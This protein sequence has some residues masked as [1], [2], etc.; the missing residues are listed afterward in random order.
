MANGEQN[1][2]FDQLFPAGLPETPTGGFSPLFEP[3]QK[4]Q[5]VA[6]ASVRAKTS[7][8]EK[9]GYSPDSPFGEAI[10]MGA[11]LVSGASRLAGNLA[12]LPVDAISGMAQATVPDEM[13]QAYN[14]SQ[15]N[16]ASPE[17]L[18]L[19]NQ[20]VPGDDGI[21]QTYLQRIEGTKGLQDVG[22][23]VDDF[24]DITSIV[25]TT[26]RDRLSRDIK[27]ETKEGVEGIR[28][29]VEQ[30][31]EGNYRDALKEGSAALASTVGNALAA[32]MAQPGAVGEY[33]VEN[34]P[35]LA[36]A[37]VNPALALSTNAGYGFDV[38]REGMTDYVENNNGQL[39]DADERNQMAG[40]A[41]A[42][43]LA[44]Q[45]GDVTM[46]R[47]LRAAEKG[48]AG[49]IK[50]AASAAG[51]VAGGSA[52]EGV[53]EGFQTYAEAKAALKS[54]TLEEVV[55]GA[56]IGALVGGNF[57]G[58]AEVANAGV[59]AEQTKL[60]AQATEAASQEA[61]N[62]AV[63][64][65][66][67]SALADPALETYDPARAVDALNQVSQGATAEQVQANL[68]QADSIQQ[69]LNKRVSAVQASAE[70]A[71]ALR[72]AMVEANA[73]QA[74]MD[75]ID[76]EIATLAKEE[77]AL[78]TQLNA[79][80]ASAERMRIDTSPEQAD[81][82]VIA[83]EA[84]AGNTESADRI[85]TLTMTN[86][87][88]IPVEVAES[89]AQSEAL[90]VPQRTA[91][92]R[93][94][95]AQV[96]ANEL[97]GRTGVRS[98]I[99]TGGDGF[100]GIPQ[101]RNA[102]RMA[103]ANGNVEAARSQVDGLAS[104]A[105]SRVS[106]LEAITAAY[107][108]V[109]GTDAKINIV[110]DEQG[111]WGPTDLKGTALKKAGGL[112]IDRKSFKLRDDVSAEA[113]VLAKT[114]AAYSALVDA[115][116]APVAAPA[117]SPEAAPEQVTT[118]T[119]EP[120]EAT[121]V[122]E[123][124]AAPASVAETNAVEEAQP[125]ET[126]ED[127][128][129]SVIQNRTGEPVTAANY[130]QVN[131][132]GELF[133]QDAGSE[134]SASVRPLVAHKDFMSKVMAGE[135]SYSDVLAQEG[136]LTMPQQ[137]A[138]D[139]FT[140]F[141]RFAEQAVRDVFKVTETRAK[142]PDFFY[143]DMAQF[144]QGADGTLDENLVTAVSYGMFS[145]INENAT[146]LRNS[147]EGINAILL[148]DFDAEISPVERAALANLG[149]RE[150]VV[151]SQL[152]GRIM[153]ALGLRPTKDA[154]NAEMSKLEATIGARA[155]G[156]MSN[157]GLIT[158]EQLSDV[159]LQAL[160]KSGEPG[161]KNMPHTFVRVKANEVDGKMVA[162]PKVAR[163]RERNTGSQ[164]VVSKVFGVE[165]AGVE[166]SYQPVPF[167]QQFAKRTRQDVPKVLAETL[168]KEG[169]KAHKLR[170]NMWHVWGRLSKQAL[171]AM[172][173]AVETSDVP[174]HIE[175][176][177]GL[178][179]K[180]DGI[181]AQVDNLDSFIKTMVADVTTEGL[182]QSLYFGRSVWKPQRVGLST[183][184]INPQTSKVHRHMLA[185]EGW[186]AT[187]N[188]DNPAQL[189]N[190]QLRILEAFGVKTEADLTS[191]VLAGYAAK[192]TD[193]AAIQAGVDALVD[194]L[195][196]NSVPTDE[197]AI[198]AAVKEG[199]ENFHSFDAL[200][201]LAEEKIA[202]Q[203]N[204]TGFTTQMMGEVDGLTNGPMLSIA[205][206]GAKGWETLIQG[207]FMPLDSTYTQFNEYK[208]AGGLDLYESNIAAAVSRLQGANRAALDAL[209]VITGQLAT[210][211][212]K[213]TKKGRN[214]IK[215]PLTALMFG[216]N[217]TTAVEGMA[218]GFIDSIYSKM[219][220][221]AA[222]KSQAE[223]TE[224]L[225]ALNVL[226]LN[227]K[228]KLS[229]T[230]SYDEALNTRLSE[231]QKEE[232]KKSFYE[233]LGAPTEAALGDTYA[234]FIAR[235]NVINQTAQLA[236]NVYNAVRDG[237]TEHVTAGSVN[238]PRNVGGEAIRTL[239]RAQ[240][241]QVDAILK[242]MAPILQTA[243]S[244]ASEQHT[245]GMYMAKSQRRMDSTAPFES[246]VAFG[247]PVETIAM[248]GNMK[249]I[250]SSKISSA[251]VGDID[252]G[253]MP[254]ITSIHSMDS[255]IAS[256]VYGSMEA[257]NVHDALGVDLDNM[258]KVGQELNKATFN[259]LMNYSSATAMSNMLD[260]VLAGAARVLQDEALA[261]K[262]QPRL[263]A[264]AAARKAKKQG[265]IV[266]QVT[267]I[268]TTASQADT[269]KLTML[270]QMKAVGQ[271]ATEG[272]S[273]MVTEADRQA[274]QDA[275]AKVGSTF[276][277]ASRAIAE[278][279]DF[280]G[281]MDARASTYGAAIALS[282]A[283]LRTLAPATS[284]NT[285]ASLVSTPAVQET[286][287]VM[288]AQ[289]IPLASALEALPEEQAAEV[290]AAVEAVVG[291]K[292]S[293]WGQLGNPV[294]QSDVNLV[295]MLESTPDMT[296]GQLAAALE[297]YVADPFQKTLLKMVQRALPGNVQVKYITAATGPEGAYGEGVDKS[298]G[299][300]AQRSGKA[301]V[302]VKSPEFVE[303]G[304]TPEMLTHELVHAALANLV[305]QHTGKQSAVGRAVADLEAVRVS[306]AQ[307][308]AN[309]GALSAKYRNA[310][311]N[312]QELLA[313]GLTNQDF[314]REV[315]AMTNAPTRDTGLLHNLQKFIRK[316]TS[317]LFNG[318]VR[319]ESAMAALVAQSAGL[320]REAAALRTAQ[321]DTT[322]KYEDEMDAVNQ[323]TATQ[324][325]D[326]MASL[327][328]NKPSAQ[329][330]AYLRDLLESTV[331]PIYGPY[332]VTKEN[333]KRNM[334][335]TPLD[336]LLKAVQT[337]NMPFSSVAATNAFITT[338][339][340]AF[341]LESVE[342]VIQ[343]AMGNPNTLFV[344]GELESLY[345]K[346]RESLK[347]R[348]FHAGDWKAASANEKA[349]A[350]AKYDFL[351]RPAHTGGKS[352]YLSRFAA[353]GLA[354]QEVRNVLTF[355][356]GRADVPLASL[357]WASR[358]TELF[359]RIMTRLAALHTKVA[360]GTRADD[361]LTT[362]VEQL[363]DIE[364]KRK[365]Q[366]AEAKVI[367][368]DQIEAFMT[369]TAGTVR[370][371]LDALGQSA[372]MRESR[373]PGF[374]LAGVAMSTLA[375]DRLDA[376]LDHMT[377]ARDDAQRSRHGVVMGLVTEWRG[378]YDS[379]RLAS[380]LFKGAK[381][382]EQ[383]RK[384]TI[385][386]TVAHVNAAFADGG[387]NLTD[388][389]RAAITKFFLKTNAQA[390]EQAVGLDQLK[391]MLNDGALMAQYR[392]ELEAQVQALSPEYLYMISQTKDLAHHRVVGGSTSANLMQS[393]ANITAMFGTR[394]AGAVQP[395]LVPL[396][397]QL[398]AVYALD[399]SD[400][401]VRNHAM[402]VLRSETARG[403]E[404]GIAFVLALHRGLQEKSTKEL[405]NG[406]EALQMTGYT[407]EIHDN[408]IEVLLVAPKDVAA[409]ERAGY[410]KG[411]N[412]QVDP[413]YK[414]NEQRVLMTR[415][416]AGQTGLLTGAM[417]FTGMNSRGSSPVTEALNMLQGTQATSAK[418]KQD[419]ALAKASEIAS[420]FGRS[421][422]YDPRRAKPGHLAPTL[423]PDGKIADYRY[424]M[425]E[426]NR[427][428][429][430]DRDSS[431]DQVLGV[432]AGQ[433]VDKVSTVQQNN[434]VV[435]AL[436]D[437][438]KADF[439]NRPASYL[440]VGPD[441]ADASLAEAYR[442][443]PESTKREIKKVWKSDDMYIPADQVD[444]ILGYRK[445]SLTSAFSALPSDRNLFEKT[446][447]QVT[448][449]I[450]GEK[451]ELR[452]GQAED[453]IQSLVGE[454]KDILVVKNVL[455]LVGNIVSNMTLLAWEGV[456]IKSALASHAVAIKGAL[457]YRNDA[458]RLMQLEQALEIG[459]T[460][461]TLEV[462]S[463]LVALRDRM[464]RNPI[465][466]LVDA[467]L[468]PTI[469]E[470]VQVNDDRYSYKSILARKVERFSSKVPARMR[471]LGKQVYMTH[472][473]AAY[474]FLSQ[475]TQLSDLVAR[476]ALYEHAISRTQDPLSSA[477]ALKLAE[478]S[479]VNYDLPSHRTIQYMNDMGLVM[480]TK[481]YLRIQKVIMRLVK[482]HPARG[483]MLAALN[484]YFSGLQSVMDSSWINKLGN[485]P[486][487]E[488][489]LGFLGA[490]K[491]L[492]AFKL[493]Q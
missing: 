44:E 404:N 457:S 287:A 313:W 396:L 386:N 113:D 247:A 362:L 195:R 87:D 48:G 317:M 307:Y 439:N 489:A 358:L 427:D 12:T 268:R 330:S 78:Q 21:P 232:L 269:D 162:D 425:T 83:E 376:V 93:F 181:R 380:E 107:E 126:V 333:A 115:A 72:E 253:V 178:N 220:G 183:N 32:G 19:L 17:D 440:Q 441:V 480:F 306:A 460:A 327:P 26:K 258:E 45:V 294:V 3:A 331:Q 76:Q 314:Q 224:I 60:E 347:P 335:L 27:E 148:R 466:P 67:V 155:L 69:D 47:G 281:A 38:W 359:R 211:E 340:E 469:V 291:D 257:L 43:A 365:L 29:A 163:I 65:G 111:V 328:G 290:V 237:V 139:S 225:R 172:G 194:V 455:T 25:D 206:L 379:R 332:D 421:L 259:N 182:E 7:L 68:A 249:G 323:L 187:V 102:I 320:F 288:E 16:E 1:F 118:P 282:A 34:I 123:A 132:V 445:Y 175:N 223:M 464:A 383:D 403:A 64:T 387:V 150:S 104:F 106:K 449:A 18:A 437:Q 144:L 22:K 372:F 49:G 303:S 370:E 23:T 133:T 112:V 429:L 477:D 262:I 366:L 9:M 246:E 158:R 384:S 221:A 456:P 120:V 151:A 230:M 423:A 39:P 173:G 88:S 190:Y 426:H 478:D 248:D 424:L 241:D 364:A 272:G 122:V 117:V 125:E 488:S 15:R 50:G 166:P 90:T 128:R 279:L 256:T 177:A 82:A 96:A 62:Q 141:A 459:Y 471:E 468:L 205:M 229:E 361:A 348:N 169:A 179:A 147:D 170:Q 285:L 451:A 99:A 255:S 136:P 395:A 52:R 415:R 46:L 121:P 208:A 153:Q 401:E 217:P 58:A 196:D 475:A 243:M 70:E 444:L 296:A 271:Y 458:K 267:A 53:T 378:V 137:A 485:N 385:E 165:A 92:A 375:G 89:L 54:P 231:G 390:I 419:I 355:G 161:N 352:A 130:T 302:F 103:L 180:S 105:A 432:M 135:V 73:P 143:R 4:S 420:L 392:R 344:R 164:S 152:G 443:L 417:S 446:L 397:D 199:G 277:P 239:T 157:L 203:Y 399:Y 261:A 146:Q 463:E 6:E 367:G 394:K 41:A 61:F 238:V 462:E 114:A 40:Y 84:Q 318:S 94:S 325:F 377:K 8:I 119:V 245:A 192:V 322:L 209:Q 212:G 454:M 81:V 37:A 149:T 242:D 251:T 453:M 450:L 214:A 33:V 273:Y 481:Y 234:T 171:Y 36:A 270:S 337:G 101:Y 472:D 354:S 412:L 265:N 63:E 11:S 400:N 368:M 351:F 283:S 398:L 374:K 409:H 286:M 418:V 124:E 186:G 350:L 276:A 465:K 226:I 216:S 402:E 321:P 410:A 414:L 447:V 346:A 422:A 411:S 357:P 388:P 202:R 264:V 138:L 329:H 486:L 263:K 2:G 356:T 197:A 474:K 31:E 55:E 479:F 134:T 198:L 210:D 252:P 244:Q 80:T 381:A 324:V 305:D 218:D 299:W 293:V 189:A 482:E 156:A 308:I 95:E 484:N 219:E 97:K 284:L 483:L 51:S 154:T 382:I 188:F 10:N 235:R 342:A 79:V 289:N 233:L 436:Y 74:H 168:E 109:K 311:S 319:E 228:L 213:V 301:T 98:D 312:V 254:F 108:Q 315:L 240:Q 431:M 487:Q 278:Q 140:S 491:E 86:P 280:F 389:Q 274:A 406:T 369:G 30:F 275:L 5:Q 160:M 250:G 435:G 470:D 77:A 434:D 127:G 393:T 116:P 473:T 174:T 20:V 309:H 260:Q 304:V 492:P 452:V 28:A 298:R 438:Y 35:Q 204:A 490:L 159:K 408:K 236:F 467:G 407:P 142:R 110:R 334:A 222:N 14:R 442:L 371:K 24:F 428:V 363:V 129:L 493:L 185:M 339:E 430:L 167:E 448:G 176:L 295:Q 343:H 56:T 145:W 391:N 201:A 310:T 405:F 266:G 338:Q 413:N 207:G 91:L 66:D 227:K 336:V 416:G 341:V 360:Q 461:R 75:S 131:L 71:A 13:V 215:K 326:S 184:V 476:Y 191:N 100:K 193:N 373:I 316:I 349:I 300:F 433:I 345:N 200:V 42:A 59:R 292:L 57:Q 353:L 85:L 297:A